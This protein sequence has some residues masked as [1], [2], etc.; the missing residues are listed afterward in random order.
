MQVTAAEAE[1]RFDHFCFQAK[2]E[3][4]IVEKDGRPDV[5]MLSY[6]EYLALI[7]SAEPDAPDSY[8]SQG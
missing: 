7:S 5:V 6:E 2:S 1:S 4:I 3:P 8:P